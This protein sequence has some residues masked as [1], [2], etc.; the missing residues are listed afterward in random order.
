M[1]PAPL[2]DRLEA[3]AHDLGLDAFGVAPAEAS[4]RAVDL[5]AHLAAGRH[6][7]M[8]WLARDP[9]RRADPRL[10]LPGAR[11]LIVVALSYFTTDP[12]PGLWNDPLRGR[13]ARYA[14]GR[15]YHNVLGKL[16]RKLALVL[17]REAPGVNWRAY[18][19]TGPVMEHDTAL[20]AGL[21]FTGKN[22]LLLH[23][24]RGSYLHLG[25][26]L[27]D[28][29]LDP[30]PPAATDGGAVWRKGNALRSCG[31]CVKCQ[32]ACPT[33]A[34]PV[35]Y[36]LDA[37]RCIAY[38]TIE[39]RGDIPEE[40]RPGFGNWIFGCD[41]C[42]SVCPWVRKFS[43][44]GRTR[45]IEPDPDRMAPALPDLLALD[46]DAFF[47]RYAGTP[48]MRAKRRGLQRNALVALGN[49]RR[50]EAL[51][52][53]LALASNP[54]PLLASHAAWAVRRLEEST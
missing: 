25:V 27:T 42:Q 39:N 44:P 33:R 11:S 37:R 32:D 49:S 54:D 34:F 14:W 51:P 5:L 12:P 36:V 48:L 15:D 2:R 47:R 53:A 24:S 13:V 1:A 3:A 7:D 41:E 38:H 6:A 16:L 26:I 40:L 52:L 19:D 9:H 50:P 20:R 23:P 31:S 30:D 18:A 35:P 28:A 10:V 46:D 22:T 4:P 21:G 29:E 43:V 8:E 45:Y 17:A